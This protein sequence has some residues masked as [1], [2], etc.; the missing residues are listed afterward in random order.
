MPSHPDYHHELQFHWYVNTS[1]NIVHC[2]STAVMMPWIIGL[3]YLYPLIA[4]AHLLDIS[5][6]VFATALALHSHLKPCIKWLGIC[7][8]KFPYRYICKNILNFMTH[9]LVGVRE[10][11]VV[12]STNTSA[13]HVEINDIWAWHYYHTKTK[14][15]LFVAVIHSIFVTTWTK[16]YSQMKFNAKTPLTMHHTSFCLRWGEKINQNAVCPYKY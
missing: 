16:C 15:L 6:R 8:R 9:C 3:L 10:A 7:S 12:N 11:V 14:P 2:W 13:M 1:G 4:R 5:E